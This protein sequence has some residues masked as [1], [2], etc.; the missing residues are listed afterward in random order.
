M[1][2][3]PAAKLADWT[4]LIYMAGDNDLDDFGAEDIKEMKKVGSSDRIHILVQRDTAAAGIP[5]YRYRVQKGTAMKDDVLM[6]LGE[7]N[8][9]DP[10][11]L[12]DF[13]TWGMKHYPAQRTM[14]VLWNHGSGWDDT[15]IYA[16]ARHRNLR[17]GDVKPAGSAARRSGV[18]G[19]AALPPTFVRKGK[20]ATR[21]YRTSFFLSAF[22][23]APASGKQPRRAI[24]FDDEAQDFLDSVEM[25][26][27]F[28]RITKKYGR[29]FDLIGMDACLM[30]MIEPVFQVQKCGSVFC[31]S[32]ESEPGK[33]WPYDKVLAKLAKQP[34]MSGA[35]LATIIV[36]EYSAS[37]PASKAVTQTALD[38]T[39]LTGVQQA[40]DALGLIL[41]TNLKT[42]A[43]GINFSLHGQISAAR[44][45]AQG[46][47]HPDYVDLCDF[48][49]KLAAYWPK[50]AAAAKNI[51]AAVKACVIANRAK[52]AQVRRS[53]GIS[54]Y[55]P[56]VEVNALYAKLDFANGN[57][58]AFLK[59]Y[60]NA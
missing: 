45:E 39:K 32:Q 44:K 8:T 10:K 43:G 56:L 33:G 36:D 4:L 48:A 27:V 23:M 28:T 41:K 18:V 30:S 50:A 57:W 11:V 12:E 5:A 59:A 31:G 19:R 35:Q 46:Y 9:G 1:K 14:A 21:R 29:K 2:T 6:D 22:E 52:H 34:A 20:P 13:L 24:A 42:A 7:T 58:H 38:L 16:E 60:H 25:K 53:N 15:D 55:L 37:Y 40:A 51:R 3:A 49:D 17:P 54:I 26:N 47:D